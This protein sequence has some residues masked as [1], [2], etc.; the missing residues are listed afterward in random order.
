MQYKSASVNVSLKKSL[1]AGDLSESRY[2][3]TAAVWIQTE[4]S[5]TDGSEGSAEAVAGG[6]PSDGGYDEGLIQRG[7]TLSR[8]L[9][10][11]VSGAE[12]CQR[13]GMA[14]TKY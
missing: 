12:P 4:S 6:W 13:K 9:G 10:A 8:Q 7:L 2:L 5:Y 14:G 11:Q 1:V 3:L